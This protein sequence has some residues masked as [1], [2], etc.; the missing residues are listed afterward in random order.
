MLEIPLNHWYGNQAHFCMASDETGNIIEIANPYALGRA[1]VVTMDDFYHDYLA[2][3]LEDMLKRQIEQG[4]LEP[5]K[6]SKKIAHPMGASLT[7]MCPIHYDTVVVSENV[8]RTDVIVQ[9]DIELWDSSTGEFRSDTVVQWFRCP[10]ICDL[11]IGALSIA[12]MK[13]SVYRKQ[14]NLTGMSLDKY[15]IPIIPNNE[16]D[17][18]A[19]QLL[20]AFYPEALA[21]PVP[22]YGD[23]LAARIGYGIMYAAIAKEHTHQ[24]QC[25]FA[26]D[27]IESYNATTHSQ[28]KTQIPAKTLLIDQSPDR[29]LPQWSAHDVIVHECLHALLDKHFYLLQRLFN[30][31]LSCLPSPVEANYWG[32]DDKLVRVIEAR[33]AKLTPRVR[34][35]ATQTRKKIEALLA[36]HHV[37]DRKALSSDEQARKLRTV[38]S[39]LSAFYCVS[40]TTARLRM[41]ELG[42]DCAKGIMNYYADNCAPWHSSSPGRLAWN[43]TFTISM[44]DAAKAYVEDQRFAALIDSG[45]FQYVEGHFCLDDPRYVEVDTN[46]QA[47]LTDYARK[48]ADE[49]CLIFSVKGWSTSW[50]HTRGALYRESHP[51]KSKTSFSEEGELTAAERAALI[52]EARNVH[53]AEAQLPVLFSDTLA[54]HMKKRGMTL[55]NLSESSGISTRTLSVWRN[56]ESAGKSVRQLMALCIG[57]HLEP[58]LSQDLFGK[59]GQHFIKT[60]EHALYSIILRTMYRAPLFTC[61]A[62]LQDAGIK[63]LKEA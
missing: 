49:C 47:R 22:V 9:T 12:G 31:E 57:L 33:I 8:I 39:E 32:D 1:R 13:P 34:M 61:N 19:E 40:M 2:Y 18:I 58:E 53:K 51:G 35:P 27:T 59:G 45:C 4:I 43:Q 10:F 62:V 23:V 30:D 21:Q 24:G 54:Y 63:P 42:Y 7:A 44:T 14:D 50:E 26:E 11:T 25:F 41:I 17:R 5:H 37:T 29:I 16:L 6:T 38:I 48:H 15:L 20:G 55:E 60:E 56:D 52:A 46:G 3:Y 36:L 28:E